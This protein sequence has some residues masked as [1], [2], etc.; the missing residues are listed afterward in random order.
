MKSE[1]CLFDVLCNAVTVRAIR[2]GTVLNM[3][4]FW[5]RP[6]GCMV[7]Y[8]GESTNSIDYHNPLSVANSDSRQIQVPNWIYRQF[9]SVNYYVVRRY[10][11]Q[12]YCEQSDAA[13]IKVVFDQAGELMPPTA[14]RVFKF[15]AEQI[16]CDSFEFEWFYN[17]L[18][19]KDVPVKFNLCWDGGSGQINYSSPLSIIN[20]RGH[21]LYKHIQDAIEPGRYLFALC[22]ADAAGNCG[23]SA[24]F[25]VQLCTPIVTQPQIIE[26]KNI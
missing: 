11:S 9:N 3:G 16:C 22:A 4:W 7:L 25:A 5:N 20:Y 19:Q 1:N 23:P 21:G 24:K 26:I 13:A 2:L 18:S 6:T 15:K 8:R 12:G 14:N 10:N 17:P